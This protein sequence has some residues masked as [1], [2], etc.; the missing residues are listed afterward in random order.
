MRH[1]TPG[2][3]RYMDTTGVIIGA[4]AAVVTT[5]GGVSL[6]RLLQRRDI[7]HPR[8][9]KPNR[10]RRRHRPANRLCV[11]IAL[12]HRGR[13]I[14]LVNRRTSE[15]E[16][17]WQF[18]ARIV[19]PR[20]RPD[21]VAVAGVMEETNVEVRVLQSLGE[22]LH[23]QTQVYCYYFETVFLAGKVRNRQPQENASVRWA[24]AG[25]IGEYL[26]LD[27]VHEPVR[28]RLAEISRS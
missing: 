4:A 26:D 24:E 22:R 1:N 8:R 10:F 27:S 28:H 2:N 15:G 19:K 13:D 5:I 25:R 16:T 11:S 20:E 9:A 6:G 18:P 14:L 21:S 23:P 3:S 12:V 17:A 7:T